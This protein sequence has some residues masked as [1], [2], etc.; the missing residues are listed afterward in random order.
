[1]NGSRRPPPRAAV[2][3][4]SRG[5][6]RGGAPQRLGF[7]GGEQRR[8][9]S[10]RQHADL[11][12]DRAYRLG[13]AAV[14]ARLAVEDALAHDIAL[15]LEEHALDGF[16]APLGLLAA[17]EGREGLGLDLPEARVSLLLLGDGIGL[18]Q[19]RLR[20][21]G[22]RARQLRALRQ[23]LPAPARLARLGGELPDGADGDLH[24]LVSEYDRTPHDL[25][26]EAFGLRLAHQNRVLGTA[27][28]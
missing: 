25:L 9:M 18:G 22:D 8:A 19:R 16:R 2:I 27:Q 13:V 10:T 17:G 15:E 6:P 4:P 3:F 28:P 7:P 11:D 5:V 26:G 12:R 20:M 24:L 23:R 14:D 1:M 21:Q